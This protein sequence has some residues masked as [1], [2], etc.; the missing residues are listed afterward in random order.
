MVL[1]VLLITVLCVVF[2]MA[3]RWTA[4]LE[5]GSPKSVMRSAQERSSA[6]KPPPVPTAPDADFMPISVEEAKAINARLAISAEPIQPAR[7]FFL[8]S[9]GKARNG[10]LLADGLDNRTMAV[11]CMTAAIYYEAGGE[12]MQGQRAVAQVVL[13]RVRHPAFPKSI[14]GVVYQGAQLSTGCQFSFTCD[15]SL[16]RVPSRAGW[17]RAR[18]V[19]LI[20]L[21]G[22]VEP[23]VGTATHYHADFVVPYWASSLNKVTTI[24]AHIFYRWRGYWGQR[25]AFSGVYAGEP[26]QGYGAKLAFYVPSD[27]AGDGRDMAMGMESK[28]PRL[29]ADQMSRSVPARELALPATPGL[30]AD[31]SGGTLIADQHSARLE[32]ARPKSDKMNMLLP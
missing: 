16:A 6:L 14:C 24:G 27:P 1:S 10:E 28:A 9:A 29:L 11:D 31:Q 21:N 18:S 25:S 30:R 20:A 23:N 15:G 2:L 3:D 8:A 12:S 7:P 4:V 13:N 19:S 32:V 26:A 5:S 22:A 17:L